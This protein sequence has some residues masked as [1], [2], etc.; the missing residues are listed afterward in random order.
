MNKFYTLLMA[1]LIGSQFASAQ[2][3][4]DYASL[5]SRAQ[6]LEKKYPSLVKVK[7]L[8]KTLGGKDIWMLSI[9]TGNVAE[10]PAIA[11]V[12]GVEG[13]HLLGVELAIGFAEKLLSQSGTDSV[14][15]LL[16]QQT[17]YVFPNMSPDAT[18]Q[19]FAKLKYA[20][21]G[22]AKSTDDD[23]DAAFNE[24]GFEDL[25]GDGKITMMRV[26]DPTGEWITSPDDER[27]MVKAELIK[28]QKGKYTLLTEGVDNDK[29]GKFNEDGEGGV[30]FNKNMSYN[31]PNFVPGSGEH[32]VSEL[33]NRALLDFL[34][35]AYNVYSVITFGPQ[36][37]LSNPVSFSKPGI[38]KR[39]ITSWYEE[40]VK[41]NDLVSK[42]YNKT[43]KAKGAPASKL[44][45]GNFA[46]WAYFHYGRFSFSTPGWWV[47]ETKPDT[48]KK[49][50]AFV[51]KNEETAYLRWAEKEN[52]SETFTPWTVIKHPDFLARKVEVGGIDSFS[53]LN[54][55]Y[56]LVNDL[57]TEHTKFVMALSKMAPMVEPMNIKT[58]KLEGG[59]TRISLD[60]V[61]NG[62]FA[63]QT[64]VG[65]KS[66]WVKNIQVKLETSGKV[67]SGRA[68]QT[69]GIIP[70]YGKESLSWLI[71]GSGKVTVTVASPS[72]GKKTI[73]VTL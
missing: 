49:Q 13:S 41:V 26:E 15:N 60:V 70:S 43:V 23:R 27:V 5:T 11:V 72:N 59:L 62:A 50:K 30:A 61:N 2:D 46:D 17:Y 56:K 39:V 65:E 68:N 67:I 7:S 73:S 53:L 36:N 19:Y 24:D 33:E 38:S 58:E 34:F 14:K 66:N 10:K 42:T 18:E 63:T 45:E 64:K 28:G 54:P 3:Y 51:D 29:D 40:D 52:I 32:M 12:G 1:C 44:T 37:N 20:R 6:Q 22:N 71:S 25:N 9:G 55:P 8:T 31:Y 48:A 57:V 21:S 4:S 69:L 16:N 47:P 35:E